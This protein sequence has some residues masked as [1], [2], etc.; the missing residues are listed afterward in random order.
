[1][2][3]YS[4]IRGIILSTFALV[5]LLGAGCTGGTSSP[6]PVGKGGAS[7]NGGA[8][9]T[10]G[11]N[12]SGGSSATG[13]SVSSGGTSGSG[14]VVGSG[15]TGSGGTI[16]GTGGKGSG[17]TTTSLGGTT[18][19]GGSGSGGTISGAGGRGSGGASSSTGGNTSA[20]GTGSGGTV[21]GSGGR[22]GTGGGDGGVVGTGGK[23][24]GGSTGGGTGTTTGGTTGTGG[25]SGGGGYA[26]GNPA[27]PSAGCGTA[28][29]STYKAGAD[30]TRK[31]MTSAGLSREYII[32]IPTGY[33]SSKPYRLV[34]AWH[35]MGSSDTGAVSSGYYGGKTQDTG[36]TTIFVAPQGYTDSMPWR[37][38]D[39]DH[40]FFDDMLKL[41]KSDLCID[42]SRVFTIGFSF[43]GME[44]Y[45]LSV[46]RQKDLRAGV[47]IAPANY[48]IYVPP[49]KTHAPIAWMQT[50]G[51]SDTTCPWVNG[52]STTQGSKFIAIEHGTDNGCTVPN[53][54]PT[55]TSGNHLC[56]DFTGCKE[57]YPTKICTFNGPHTDT[58]NESGGNWIYTEGWKFITQF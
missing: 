36:K 53:P 44:T 19:A 49:T 15:G 41:F 24:T 55:W 40:T 5:L 58:S 48:N 34:F 10:G 22:T 50:T 51:M 6:P 18:S 29:P 43:G 42:E 25:S 33:D 52:S 9:A 32:Y 8:S 7:G 38:D 30:T 26:I 21:A 27:V 13:G 17:G 4:A 56:V 1:M 35:C 20:G 31:D 37:S 54:I 45:S 3:G 14:G 57:G 47:G 23:A 11:V 16:S 2:L 39:K 12:G 46:D 28:L